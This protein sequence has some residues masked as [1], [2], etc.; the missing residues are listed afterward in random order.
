M[1]T[2]EEKGEQDLAQNDQRKDKVRSRASTDPK[3]TRNSSAAIVVK[4]QQSF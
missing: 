3:Q 4:R 1:L 2:E